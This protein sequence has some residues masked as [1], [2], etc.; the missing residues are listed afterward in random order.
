MVAW[1]RDFG[2]VF[3]VMQDHDVIP[4][5]AIQCNH[6]A[7]SHNIMQK[8][9][10]YEMFTDP[11]YFLLKFFKRVNYSHFYRNMRLLHTPPLMMMLIGYAIMHGCIPSSLA[12][13]A[14][15]TRNGALGST[16]LAFFSDLR[17]FTFKLF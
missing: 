5:S 3:G 12:L 2:A 10:D 15:E 6:G 17:N 11:V 1:R 8:R 13:V 4:H 9:L 14:G 7:L 16:D